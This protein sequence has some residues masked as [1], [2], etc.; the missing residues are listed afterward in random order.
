MRKILILLCT[1]LMLFNLNLQAQVKVLNRFIQKVNTYKNLSYTAITNNT[2]PFGDS[3][4]TVQAF[5]VINSVHGLQFEFKTNHD[6]DFF[7]GIKL[8]HLDYTNKFFF[9]KDNYKWANSAYNSIPIFML[10]DIIKQTLKAPQKIKS[11]PDTTINKI[12]CFHVRIIKNDSLVRNKRSYNMIDV[13]LN[14]ITSLPAYVV[15]DQ[16]G[17]ISKGG[18]SSDDVYRL[19]ERSGY[20]KYKFNQ[21]KKI[22][23]ELVKM[24]ANFITMEAYNNKSSNNPLPLLSTGSK[25][26]EWK[27]Q[28]TKGNS[29]SSNNI[30]NKVIL[31]DFFGNYCAPCIMSLPAINRLHERYK[32]ADVEIVSIDLDNGKEA[33]KFA[34]KYNI[35]YPV[36]VNGKAVANDFHVSGIPAFYLIDKQGIVVTTYDGYSEDLEKN[37]ITQIDKL[38]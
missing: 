20:L 25:A 34:T 27:L 38:K 1:T 29:Y 8:L 26:P 24:P 14:K 17:Y 2:S 4:D 37:L 21:K 22:D 7:D 9:T 32:D 13:Y 35:K 10:V 18:I 5:Q 11:L 33:L 23:L 19:T 16:Q 36:Y 3:A 6:Q 30:K 28:D 12:A 15:H 31:I